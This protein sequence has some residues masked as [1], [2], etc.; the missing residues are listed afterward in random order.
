MAV[1]FSNNV[2]IEDFINP[3]HRPLERGKEIVL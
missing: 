1:L 3:S 2:Q